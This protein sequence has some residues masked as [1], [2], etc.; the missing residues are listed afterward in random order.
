MPDPAT[1]AST[2]TDDLG[3]SLEKAWDD[4]AGDDTPDEP[5]SA[6]A[7][8]PS[9]PPPSE[10]A[11][12]DAAREAS[13]AREETRARDA[14]TGK[15]TKAEKAAVAQAAQG[16]AVAAPGVPAAGAPE[17]KIPE[18]W[19][20][21]VRAE[22]Q[23]IH[24]A[25]PQHAQWLMGQYEQ[26]RAISAQHYNKSQEHLR[27]YEN[28]LAPGRQARALKG[29]DDASYV[30]NLIAAGDYLD[31]N[32]IAGLKHLAKT[33]GIEDQV[34]FL[35]Q[36]G[37]QAAEIPPYVR[38]LQEKTQRMEQWLATQVHGAEQQQLQAA[39]GWIE[40]FASQKDEKGL[41]RYPYFDECIDEIIVNVQYQ[42]SKGQQVDVKAAY[43][44]AVWMNDSVRLKD[45][46]ARS[47]AADK[48]AAAQRVRD[49]EDAKRATISVSGS[50]ADTRAEAPDDL[51][52][53]L[54][55]NYDKFYS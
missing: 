51:G 21:Q 36:A 12:A 18:K 39:S 37:G 14:A 7:S 26:M 29:V 30:R 23:A 42:M 17:F 8:T 46:R 1:P 54:S 4:A 50:G 35:E 40:S 11:S 6:S 13:R 16:A 10:G 45:Q 31:K 43:D 24:A 25:N 22:L 49:I 9:A 33:Y 34:Q 3:S 38:E 27:T 44:K 52:K 32:P 41:P 55:A 47:E 15:F 19:P 48:A 2:D 53:A 20:A 28:L 5:A